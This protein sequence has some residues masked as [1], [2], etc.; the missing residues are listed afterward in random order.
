MKL[1]SAKGD[2]TRPTNARA[3]EAIMHIL[4]EELE[5]SWFV[6]FFAGSGAMGLEALSRGCTRCYLVEQNTEA[7]AAI[8]KNLAE[9]GRRL[10]VQG[11]EGQ[12]WFLIRQKA[13]RSLP[14][15]F[16]QMKLHAAPCIIFADPPYGPA[17]L[18]WLTQFIGELSSQKLTNPITLLVESSTQDA[19]AISEFFV[20][21]ASQWERLKER[22]Y[23]QAVVHHYRSLH[24]EI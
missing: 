2:T 6:D 15:L 4:R 13:A 24:P 19:A 16:K 18:Q 23:G 22:S 3:R 1:L 14:F 17:T 21:H 7:A 20:Q 8:E 12:E 10:K 5:G 9:L 11:I